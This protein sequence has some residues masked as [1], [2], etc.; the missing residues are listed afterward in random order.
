MWAPPRTRGQP[1]GTAIWQEADS[2]NG[3]TAN[4]S[5]WYSHKV[6]RRGRA[7]RFVRAFRKK[8]GPWRRYK[9]SV[10]R[11]RE[12]LLDRFAAVDQLYRAPGVGVED[13]MRVDAH[14]GVKGASEVLRGMD[15][16]RSIVTLHISRAQYETARCAC[17]GHR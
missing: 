2:R 4:R 3:C 7:R 15:F 11:S 8:I 10:R 13:L 16:F 6:P 14:L 5:A 1:G 12:Q 9:A 17:P